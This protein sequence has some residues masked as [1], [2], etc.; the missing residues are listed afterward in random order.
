MASLTD[1]YN[2]PNIA[3]IV[4]KFRKFKKFLDFRTYFLEMADE[5][6]RLQ[7]KYGLDFIRIFVAEAFEH[8]YVLKSEF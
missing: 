1:F 2:N 6:E 4:Y 3:R 7:F 5:Q 8:E